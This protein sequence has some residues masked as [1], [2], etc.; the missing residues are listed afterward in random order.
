MKIKAL[1]RSLDVH[2]PARQ[3]DPAPLSR[4]LDPALHPF[5]KPRE[6]TRALKRCQARPPLCK[7]FRRSSR[8]SH[9]WYL[10]DRKG[11]QPTQRCGIRKRRWRDPTMGLGSPKANLCLPTSSLG[12]HSV[13]LHLSVDVHVSVRQLFGWPKNAFLLHRSHGKGVGCGSATRWTWSD[14]LQRYGG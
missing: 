9:R 2:A 3:G 6:Y 11:H 8:G 14:Y 10:L 1:S 4:N 7:A 12:H 5:D 13:D